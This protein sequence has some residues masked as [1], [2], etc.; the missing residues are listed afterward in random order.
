[1]VSLAMQLVQQS[2]PARPASRAVNDF[3]AVGVRRTIW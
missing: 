1:M 2:W 3:S